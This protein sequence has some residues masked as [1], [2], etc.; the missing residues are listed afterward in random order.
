MLYLFKGDSMS[1]DTLDVLAA[2]LDDYKQRE[3]K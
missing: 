2:L 3:K 1:Q